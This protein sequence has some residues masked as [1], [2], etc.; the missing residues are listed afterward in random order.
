M[1]TVSASEIPPPCRVL[2]VDTDTLVAPL[3]REVGEGLPKVREFWWDLS[4][5][6]D[7]VAG[8]RG[9]HHCPGAPACRSLWLTAVIADYRR[10]KTPPL[11]LLRRDRGREPHVR[12]RR[13]DTGNRGIAFHAQSNQRSSCW[14]RTRS[15]S[16]V[17]LAPLSRLG[18]RKGVSGT[19]DRD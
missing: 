16:E 7:R 13:G 17:L 18:H 15:V 3:S 6:R 10:V 19:R 12:M 4:L 9:Q 2:E 14:R 8:Q 11:D 5:G 1:V